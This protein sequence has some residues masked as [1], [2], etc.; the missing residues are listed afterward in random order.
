VNAMWRYGPHLG[1]RIEALLEP[2]EFDDIVEQLVNTHQFLCAHA[3]PCREAA[4]FERPR[5]GRN[6]GGE[7]ARLALCE[8]PPMKCEGVAVLSQ[9]SAHC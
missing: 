4:G 1:D 2:P 7:T 9:S 6:G 5:V 8:Q 3:D